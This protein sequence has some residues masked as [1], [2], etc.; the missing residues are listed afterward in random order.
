MPPL[1]PFDADQPWFRKLDDRAKSAVATPVRRYRPNSLADLIAIVRDAEGAADPA[2]EVRA[3]GSHWALSTACV[4][5]RYIVETADPDF[6]TTGHPEAENQPWLNSTLYDVIPDCLSTPAQ[7]FFIAQDNVTFDPSVVPDHSKFYLY[8]VEAGTRI[9]ELYCRLDAGDDT[10][11]RSLAA[12]LEQYKGPWAMATLGGAGGQTVVGAFAT[13]THGGDVHLSPIADAVQAIH[14]V[15]PGGKQYWFE[16]LLPNGAPLVDDDKLQARYRPLSEIEID[17]DP[18]RFRAVL[19]AAG[20]MGIIYSVVLRVVRQ[21]ALHEVRTTHTWSGVK[22]WVSNPADPI[23]ASNRF[24]QVVIN[25]NPQLKI[26]DD[27]SCYVTVRTLEALDPL[28]AGT[29]PFGR[30]E[31]CEDHN[32]GHSV[33]LLADSGDFYNSICASDSPARAAIGFIIGEAVDK[34]DDALRDALKYTALL[35]FLPNPVFEL[36]RDAA[37]ATATLA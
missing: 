18:D 32:G 6:V 3:A 34:R 14:L 28:A 33:P 11:R 10:E 16:Q 21:Y 15:G 27:H 29:P 4:T 1:P 2:L 19:I 5:Q 7:R 20:R 25:P 8:H 12:Q 26:D 22:A 24:V 35:L 13:G 37:V 31:R 36:A 9:W 23:F 30:K 17:R